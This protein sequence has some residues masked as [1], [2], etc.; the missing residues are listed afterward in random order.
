[1]LAAAQSSHYASM[2]GYRLG[3]LRCRATTID[4]EP[5][6]DLFRRSP[7]DM[8]MTAFIFSTPEAASV[9]LRP[10]RAGLQRAPKTAKYLSADIA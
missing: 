9:R 4:P 3:S 2:V 8:S 7:K 6:L 5:A 1:M 10:N